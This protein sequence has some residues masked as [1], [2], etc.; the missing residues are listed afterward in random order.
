ME[1]VYGR[2]ARVNEVGPRSC[3]SARQ[4][5]PCDLPRVD[6]YRPSLN[7]LPL[8]FPAKGL[9][10]DLVQAHPSCALEGLLFGLT[11][12]AADAAQEGEV[13]PTT[14]VVEGQQR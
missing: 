9:L 11:R 4:S 2:S 12:V 3:T 6:S 14:P 10:E 5:G 7:L 8:G 1:R 13:G